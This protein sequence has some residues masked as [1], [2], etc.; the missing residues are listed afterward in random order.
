MDKNT[1]FYRAIERGYSYIMTTLRMDFIIILIVGIAFAVGYFAPAL[2]KQND[3]PLEQCAESVLE[4][5]TGID[6]DF[7]PDTPL[8]A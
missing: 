6:Y 5:E 1:V 4:R 2:T 7:S 8:D 3:S